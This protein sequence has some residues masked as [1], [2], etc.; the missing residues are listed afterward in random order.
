MAPAVANITGAAEVQTPS[1]QQTRPAQVRSTTP[2][3]GE[4]GAKATADVR[5]VI[6]ADDSGGYIYKILDRRTGE[7]VNQFPRETVLQMRSSADYSA[8]DIVA[9]QI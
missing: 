9:S 5:L 4:T 1:V 2:A 3:T 8:G 6:E 7:V